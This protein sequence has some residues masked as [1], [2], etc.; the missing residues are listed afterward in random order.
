MINSKLPLHANIRGGGGR[1]VNDCSQCSPAQDQQ[2]LLSCPDLSAAGLRKTRTA[3]D[4]Q[5]DVVQHPAS[6]LPVKK[7]APSTPK[8]SALKAP[9]ARSPLVGFQR[10]KSVR[11]NIPEEG[12]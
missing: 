1:N 8:P 3:Q 7:P 11:F 4:E 12:A 9:K 10:R 5:E 2:T 6:P